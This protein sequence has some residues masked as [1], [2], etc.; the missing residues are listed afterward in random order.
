MKLSYLTVLI[1]IFLII[2]LAVILAITYYL[3]SQP[4][5][6]NSTTRTPHLGHFTSADQQF[7]FDYPLF[8]HWTVKVTD[9]AIT[10]APTSNA[11]FTTNWDPTITLRKKM[12]KVTADFWDKKVKNPNG[13]PYFMQ[14]QA[15]DILPDN[16]FAVEHPDSITFRTSNTTIEL[17]IPSLS[18]DHGL[19]GQ[20]IWN[21]I[22][23]SFKTYTLFQDND[24]PFT[25]EYPADWHRVELSNNSKSLGYG[26]KNNTPKDVI[27]GKA[28]T[29]SLESRT[30]GEWFELS[31]GETPFPSNARP[32]SKQIILDGQGC[33]LYTIG[34]GLNVFILRIPYQSWIYEIKFNG[35]QAEDAMM[36][37][38]RLQSSFK[39]SST[40]T[41]F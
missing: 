8:D 5:A 10:Y 9:N 39:F 33:T 36:N 35:N 37:F 7:S 30:I 16:H 24:F 31:K 20:T 2:G 23:N 11:D 26:V 34:S 4:S 27:L 19:S 22:L 32:P 41:Y 1:I 40:S 18:Q 17:H 38:E 14:I 21:T 3:R 25:F 15:I 12:M 13:V 29:T 28:I 6:T